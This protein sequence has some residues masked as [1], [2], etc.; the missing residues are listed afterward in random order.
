MGFR[1]QLSTSDGEMFGEAEYAYQ[2]APGD[3]IYVNGT[4]Q[5]ACCR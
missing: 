1:Y 4:E 3:V 5:I 2:P